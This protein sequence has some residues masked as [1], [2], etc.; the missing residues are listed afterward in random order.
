M[1]P[2]PQLDREII[3]RVLK[4]SIKEME[5]QKRI[6][7]DLLKHFSDSSPE[8]VSYL[9]KKLAELETVPA[10]SEDMRCS[11]EL[12]DYLN[13]KGYRVKLTAF[14]VEIPSRHECCI[15]LAKNTISMCEFSSSESMPHA[16]AM[17]ALTYEEKF[18]FN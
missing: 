6:Y 13:H 1:K 5:V 10:Y 2:G 12:V 17:C 4:N 7:T 14:D 3:S 18:G 11:M 8:I 15:A 16:I 9:K